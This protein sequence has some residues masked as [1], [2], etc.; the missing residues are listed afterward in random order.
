MSRTVG[1]HALMSRPL[2]RLTTAHY[3]PSL[4]ATAATSH[5]VLEKQIAKSFGKAIWALRRQRGWS[6]FDVADVLE[7]DCAHVRYLKL[8]RRLPYVTELLVLA[9]IYSAVVM[10]LFRVACR[11]WPPRQR[12]R[13]SRFATY[14]WDRS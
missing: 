5:T 12:R 8:G 4:P 14:K 6:G 7:I 10:K 2:R 13:A 1:P 3:R 11:I 9:S